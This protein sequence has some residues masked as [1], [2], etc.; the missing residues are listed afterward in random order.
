[1]IKKEK[2]ES[3]IMILYRALE[4]LLIIL[5]PFILIYLISYWLTGGEDVGGFW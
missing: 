2:K 1:M 4:R 5:V 3:T